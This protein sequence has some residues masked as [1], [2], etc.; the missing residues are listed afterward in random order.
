MIAHIRPKAL[1]KKAKTQA[2]GKLRTASE[3]VEMS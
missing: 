3:A 1:N 2:P